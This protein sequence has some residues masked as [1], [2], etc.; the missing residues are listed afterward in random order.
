MIKSAVIAAAG[1]GTRLM[2]ST[3][4]T[5]KEML[6]IIDKG[7]IKP[8]LHLIIEQIAAAGINKMFIITGRGKRAI[9]DH[10]T[11]NYSVLEHLT[12]K[13]ALD[14]L[15]GFY[16]ILN[17]VKLS[18]INQPRPEG[19]GA[20]TYL[21]K[22]YV[23]HEDSFYMTSGDSI[24]YSLSKGPSTDFITRLKNAHEKVD[25]DVTIAVFETD[26][27]QRYGIAVTEPLEEGILKV[28][29]VI[30]KPVNPPSNLAICGKY[31]FKSTIFHS[32]EKT[33]LGVG[34]EKQ[35]TDAIEWLIDRGY[36]VVAIKLQPD[37]IYMDVGNPKTYIE[38]FVT[39]S[40]FDSNLNSFTKEKFEKLLNFY[41][42]NG[43]KPE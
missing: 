33:G 14:S 41:K 25:A 7:K 13:D 10:F 29:Q 2:P 23:S 5:P 36:K 20:A 15:E 8:I 40:M 28:N 17:N 31:M 21:A 27:P 18:Y 37:E 22:E 39:T 34:G 3:K 43:T 19:F 24:I 11:Q 42:N 32:L 1:R 6:P 12:D 26:T 9:E 30:E 16:K 38:A 4:E 35:L